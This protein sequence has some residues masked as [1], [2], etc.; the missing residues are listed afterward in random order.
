MK[1][2]WKYTFSS[3]W[4]TNTNNYKQS[5][6]NPVQYKIQFVN[7]WIKTTRVQDCATSG[8]RATY[9]PPSTLMWPASYIWSFLNSYIDY[10]KHWT[11]RK[12]L[13][14]HKNNLKFSLHVPLIPNLSLMWPAKPKEL[15]TPALVDLVLCLRAH[16]YGIYSL[17]LK[18]R[19][20]NNHLAISDQ[21]LQRIS[22]NLRHVPFCVYL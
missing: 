21:G 6:N 8:P 10:E 14:Y 5:I 22:N 9:G 11:S 7:S 13:L 4:N 19:H 20:T 15:S 17:P 16:L 18:N 1:Y 2:F 12:Y 3:L